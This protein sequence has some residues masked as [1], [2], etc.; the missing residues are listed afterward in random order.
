MVS[1]LHLCLLFPPSLRPL[2]EEKSGESVSHPHDFVVFFLGG[3]WL[4]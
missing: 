4:F 2:A 3:G 1:V